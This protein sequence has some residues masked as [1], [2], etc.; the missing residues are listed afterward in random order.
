MFKIALFGYS[1]AGKTTLFRILTGKKDEGYDPFKPNAGVGTYKDK[2]LASIAEIH[3]ARKTVYPE[4]EFYDFKGFPSGEGFPGGFFRNLA[5]MDA[6]ACVVNNFTDGANPAGEADSLLMELVF[7]DTER[8]QSVL[9][10]RQDNA[11]SVSS[12]QEESLKQGLKLL[13]QERFLNELPGEAKQFLQG[14]ELATVKPALVCFN[15]NKVRIDR[16]PPPSVRQDFSQQ[17]F[18]EELYKLA[19]RQLSLITFYTVKGDIARGWLV[20]AHYTA[21]QAAGSVHKDME[22]GFIKAA[23]VNFQEFAGFGSWQ[24]AKHAGALKFLG[25][26]AHL[27]DGDIVEFY[28]TPNPS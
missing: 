12:L 15:G 24:D 28:F 27:T 4:F 10:A 9:Q 5:D 1:G 18:E 7:Y 14:M 26:D 23:A 17:G 6:V 21:R 22:K 13:E 16:D 2:H 8:V 20:P 11:E 3:K 25:P 19:M